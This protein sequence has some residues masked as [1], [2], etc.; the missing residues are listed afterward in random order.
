MLREAMRLDADH[1]A[2]PVDGRCG[3]ERLCPDITIL[4]AGSSSISLGGGLV[5][6][7]RMCCGC[8][9]EREAPTAGVEH[10]H[11]PP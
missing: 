8:R 3:S 7:L 6:G 2:E 4:S 11:F 1:I 5:A 10:E 9:G